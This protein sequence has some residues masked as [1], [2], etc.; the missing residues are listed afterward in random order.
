ADGGG[1]V[2]R[3]GPAITTRFH[4]IASRSSRAAGN[5][6]TRRVDGGALARITPECPPIGAD[7]PC[8]DACNGAAAFRCVWLLDRRLRRHLPRAL[9]L[10]ARCP[11]RAEPR[12][13]CGTR[14]PPCRR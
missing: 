4:V 11:R 13:R 1:G 12:T 10:R 7:D 8:A 14:T 3:D 6:R 9:R 5:D 2:Q